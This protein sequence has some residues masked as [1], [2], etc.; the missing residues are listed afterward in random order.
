MRIPTS[1]IVMGL[2]TCVPFALAIRQGAPSHHTDDDDE[3]D[4]EMAMARDAQ[5]RADVAATKARA[6]EARAEELHRLYGAEPATL[7][8]LFGGIELGTPEVTPTQE[9][10]VRTFVGGTIELQ[11]DDSGLYAIRIRLHDD[12][13]TLDTKLGDTWGPGHTT[14]NGGTVWI[15][16]AKHS[17]A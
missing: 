12:C 14:P 10:N 9:R 17:R 7:G 16:P 3:V 4:A 8:L 1:T 13:D 11:T 5:M 6:A 15:N 2:V